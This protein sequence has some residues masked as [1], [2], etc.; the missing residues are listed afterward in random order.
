MADKEEENN[1]VT[2][3]IEWYLKQKKA[4]KGAT[5]SD[6]GEDNVRKEA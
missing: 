3:L 1:F 6:K 2:L 5:I 4:T